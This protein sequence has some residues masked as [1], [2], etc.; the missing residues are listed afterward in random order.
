M[1]ACVPGAYERL[2]HP[3]IILLRDW[4]LQNR[5]LEVQPT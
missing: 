3:N 5:D 1:S 2:D 4:R